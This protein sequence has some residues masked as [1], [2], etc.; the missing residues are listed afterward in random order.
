MKNVV[1]IIINYEFAFVNPIK[2]AAVLGFRC[3]YG[4]E[5]ITLTKSITTGKKKISSINIEPL[6]GE[7]IFGISRSEEKKR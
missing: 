7:S 3:I 2:G 5:D 6:K 1:L 4:V